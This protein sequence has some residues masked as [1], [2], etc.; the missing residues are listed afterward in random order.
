MRH[1]A[2]RALVGVVSYAHH[3]VTYREVLE[4]KTKVGLHFASI[5]SRSY[6]VYSP[7]ASVREITA[8]SCL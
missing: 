3:G 7:Y 8:K 6:F 1:A 5:A 4:W 2:R